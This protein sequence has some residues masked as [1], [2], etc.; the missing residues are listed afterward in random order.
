L[1]SIINYNDS[2]KD[3]LLKVLDLNTPEYFAIEER[4]DFELYLSSELEDY[5]LIYSEDQLIGG[6]GINYF[7]KEKKAR[8]SWDMILPDYQ[9]KG[10]GSKLLKHR[11]KRIEEK[12][13]FDYIEVRTSQIAFKFY[14][15]EGFI[16]KSIQKDFWAKGFDLY[17]MEMKIF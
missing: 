13:E 9:G 3:H 8:I 16:L 11:I 17:V 7:L 10:V 12:E 5:F 4:R 1:Y 14:E 15:K 6:G 2:Q